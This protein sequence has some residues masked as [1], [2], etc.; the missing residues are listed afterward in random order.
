[1][2]LTS[3]DLYLAA[4]VAR[5]KQQKGDLTLN[6]RTSKAFFPFYTLPVDIPFNVHLVAESMDSG[7]QGHVEVDTAPGTLVATV[8]LGPDFFPTALHGKIRIP[9]LSKLTP[10]LQG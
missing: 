5:K 2:T 8:E 1:M 9:E 4:S 6:V 3:P 10:E 7:M